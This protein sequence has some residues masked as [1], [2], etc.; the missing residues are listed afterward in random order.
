[1]ARVRRLPIPR[2]ET[3]R[4]RLREWRDEDLEPYAAMN[5]DPEVRRH[6]SP[7]RPLS[8]AEA[9][10]D[11]DSLVDQWRR[12]GFGHWAVELRETG[13]LIGRTGIKRHPDWELDPENTEVG[14]LY[15]RSAWGRGLAT[16]GAR[17]AVRFCL[18]EV[19]RHEVISIADA[20]NVASHRVMEKAGLVRAGRLRW[21][22]RDLDVVWYR[23]T[24]DRRDA[25]G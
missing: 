18:E 15:A 6:M 16:E 25:A 7:P 13:E 4:L 1:V 14:W 24:R 11:V 23:R 22:S 19:G 10:L 17:V 9:S 5:A 2:I 12:L 8:P 20:K 3:P 21:E